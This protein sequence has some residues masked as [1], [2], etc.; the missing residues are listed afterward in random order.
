MPA[1]EFGDIHLHQ[2]VSPEVEN[3]R[4][5]GAETAEFAGYYP[6]KKLV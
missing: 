2:L 6:C 5:L 3:V 1:R 4:D